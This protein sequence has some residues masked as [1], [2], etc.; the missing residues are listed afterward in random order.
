MWNLTYY[1]PKLCLEVGGPALT[2]R[3]WLPFAKQNIDCPPQKALKSRI[4]GLTFGS[5]SYFQ[6]SF[7]SQGMELERAMEEKLT[8][9]GRDW[10]SLGG[11]RD[12]G[13]MRSSSPNNRFPLEW[14]ISAESA[15]WVG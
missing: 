15:M 12:V 2:N 5:G 14:L 8:K 9:Q 11:F 1:H 3:L 13:P 4:T 6:A 7:I 10:Y